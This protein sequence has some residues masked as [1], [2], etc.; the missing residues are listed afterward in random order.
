MVGRKTITIVPCRG[1]VK[2]LSN[3][4]RE[5]GIDLSPL[6][7]GDNVYVQPL[8]FGEKQWKSGGIK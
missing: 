2:T 6:K 1:I 8:Q 5:G 4:G 3:I 7:Q